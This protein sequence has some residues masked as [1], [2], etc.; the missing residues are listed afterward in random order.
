MHKMGKYCKAYLISHLQQ[1]PQ[2]DKDMQSIWPE[3]DQSGDRAAESDAPRDFLYL[4]E[5]Y[6]VTRDVFIG[7]EIV[8]DQVTDEWKRF[9]TEVL[10]F[11]I[12][13]AERSPSASAAEA[14]SQTR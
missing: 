5:D 2:W 11:Q 10:Q 13:T 7:E 8:W 6:T 9:C 3:I 14:A 4:Q 1:Y 12:S